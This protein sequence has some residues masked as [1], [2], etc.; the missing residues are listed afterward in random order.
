MQNERVLPF[1]FREKLQYSEEK[2]LQ[3]LDD[4]DAALLSAIHLSSDSL[5][6]LSCERTSSLLDRGFLI[7]EDGRLRVS[8]AG[9]KGV[10]TFPLLG[11]KGGEM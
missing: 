9:M 4:S 7:K 6:F 11:K 3:A 2:A 8:A 10:S 1:G 5:S